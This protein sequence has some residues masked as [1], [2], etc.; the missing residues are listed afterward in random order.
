[1]TRK[2]PP[3]HRRVVVALALMTV[4]LI[5]TGCSTLNPRGSS[6]TDH[7]VAARTIDGDAASGEF[8]PEGLAAEKEREKIGSLAK[9]FPSWQHRRDVDK[10]R[11]EFSIAEETFKRASSLQGIDRRDAFRAAAT[12]YA[13]A[14]KNWRSSALEQDALLMMGESYFF[15]EDYYKAE[16]AYAE[17]VKGYSRNRYLDHVDARRFEIADYW[18]KRDSV[19]HKPF[20]MVNFT[21]DKLPLNDTAGHGKRVL[22]KMRLDNPTGKASD[23]ATMRLAVRS[24]EKGDYET[25]ADTFSDLRITYPDSEHQFQAQFLELQSLLASYQGPKYS[26]VPLTEA[27]KRVKQIARQFPKEGQEHQ[28]DLNIAYA[29][30]RYLLA[31]RHW[32]QAEF[33][34]KKQQWGS[35][36][37]HLKQLEDE[38]SDT[39]FAEQ[40]KQA[41]ATI[42]DK[43]DDPPQYL[44]PLAK[45]FPERGAERPWLQNTGEARSK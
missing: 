13:S 36:R 26:S 16:Q 10:A 44:S 15:A 41:Q 6:L 21:D 27:E 12:K 2:S 9:L 3:D 43:P 8:R 45:L 34:R 19:E 40:A 4:A 28:K 18:L 29:K 23:D 39:P 22:E 42:A 17:L 7:A 25:A 5:S 11:N 33:R 1:M 20:V 24:F 35:A 30:I 32:D 31:E 38:F 37:F 14:A